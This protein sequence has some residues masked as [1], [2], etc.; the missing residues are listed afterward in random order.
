MGSGS[1]GSSIQAFMQVPRVRFI[2]RRADQADRH[3]LHV[4]QTRIVDAQ[5][6]RDRVVGVGT[7]EQQRVHPGVSNG[8]ETGSLVDRSE[9][10]VAQ[11]RTFLINI[12]DQ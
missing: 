11:T 3:R 6:D 1:G 4:A 7:L 5:A 12:R 9:G 8:E 10:A 2:T